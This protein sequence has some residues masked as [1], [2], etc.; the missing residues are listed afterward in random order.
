MKSEMGEVGARTLEDFEQDYVLS[1]A[2]TE[3][4]GRS[5]HALSVI[6]REKVV[7][8]E[9]CDG[10][11]PL[12]LCLVPLPCRHSPPDSLVESRH[13]GGFSTVYTC[14]NRISGSK[15][16]VKVAPYLVANDYHK[17]QKQKEQLITEARV[18][19]TM[20]LALLP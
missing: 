13:R 2:E 15:A 16:A 20:R 3:V 5:V 9:C 14:T 6:A 1:T 11:T 7:V 18:S 4:L 19:D 17:T 10:D 12:A 8:V